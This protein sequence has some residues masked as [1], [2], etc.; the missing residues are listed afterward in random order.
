VAVSD[1][2]LHVLGALI[3]MVCMICD[4]VMTVVHLRTLHPEW[5]TV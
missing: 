3:G 4:D 5:R 2:E 1:V